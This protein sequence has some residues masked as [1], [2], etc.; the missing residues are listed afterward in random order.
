MIWF[1]LPVAVPFYAIYRAINCRYCGDDI[2]LYIIV[3]IVTVGATFLAAL[4]AAGIAFGI[5]SL[6]GSVPKKLGTW[7]LATLRDKEGTE[8]G[9]FLG[10][11]M[12][13]STP[14]I[15]YYSQNSDGSFSPSRTES[16]EKVKVYEEA[17]DDATITTYE[18]DFRNPLWLAIAMP[19]G[20]YGPDF[21]VPSGTIRRGY[22]L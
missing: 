19:V 22:T 13:Q 18:P 20:S 7:P 10:T 8:G 14:Y 3:A 9:F 11:G 17:R 12:I 15:F 1:L 21:R 5:G 6:I 16:T 2:P 4:V